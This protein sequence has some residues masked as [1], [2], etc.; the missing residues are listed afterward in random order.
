MSDLPIICKLEAIPEEQRV[1]HQTASQ[2]LFAQVRPSLSCQT[3]TNSRF[4]WS[5]LSQSRNLS[6]WSVCTAHSGTLGFEYHRKRTGILTLGGGADVKRDLL[7]RHS[8]GLGRS[9]KK[10]RKRSGFPL[11]SSTIVVVD[12]PTSVH[13]CME[14]FETTGGN[15][16]KSAY[17]E[18]FK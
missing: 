11:R 6:H 9:L 7:R 8:G 5:C 12:D 17:A 18:A 14:V 3:A 2:I 13:G 1:Q 4:Q 10:P 15:G 16:D